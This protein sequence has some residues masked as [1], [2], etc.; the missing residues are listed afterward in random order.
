MG[1][2]ARQRRGDLLQVDG[3]IPIRESR[4][5]GGALAQRLLVAFEVILKVDEIRDRP[6]IV[7]S[8]LR[9]AG[10]RGGIGL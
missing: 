5:R 9:A 3:P 2:H 6:A 10:W 7:R 8:G 4:A 1:V